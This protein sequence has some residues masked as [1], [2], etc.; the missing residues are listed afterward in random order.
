MDRQIFPNTLPSPT[1][2]LLT[3]L[4]NKQPA[5]LKTFYLS[6]GTALSL[7]VGHRESEDLDF[8]SADTFN[9]QITCLF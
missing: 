7:Q 6:G 4:K 3:R 5:F 2:A 8:F 9:P 1:A